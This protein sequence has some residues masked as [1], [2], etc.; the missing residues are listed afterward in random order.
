MRL[1]ISNTNNVC[2]SSPHP[3]QKRQ[4]KIKINF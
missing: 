4:T 1:V 3:L 2:V